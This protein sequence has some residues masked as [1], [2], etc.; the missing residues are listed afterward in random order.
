MSS[1]SASTG[2]ETAT[3]AVARD[4]DSGL[5]TGSPASALGSAINDQPAIAKDETDL[6]DCGNIGG[7]VAANS[8]QVGGPSNR[9]DA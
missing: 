6:A 9:N 7:R 5:A 2:V 1:F 3:C 4:A 8:R